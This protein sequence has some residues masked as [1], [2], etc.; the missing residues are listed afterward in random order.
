MIDLKRFL[1]EA[2]IN[3]TELAIAL[4]VTPQAITNLKQG[5]M[6]VPDDWNSITVDK[7]NLKLSD[8]LLENKSSVSEPEL[9]YINSDPKGK[10]IP[11]FEGQAFATISPSMADVVALRPD[12]F[13]HIP[14]FS[15]GEFALQ[16][17]GHSMRPYISHGDFVVVK[18]IMN[19]EAIIYDEPYMI[20]TKEDNLKT[21]KFVKEH[22]DKKRLWLVPYNIE[23]FNEQSIMKEDILEM[24]RVVGLFRTV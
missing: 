18:R 8:Y 16:I 22:K 12:T 6:G 10:K 24:Y 7:F 5:K 1:Y 23:Q 20:V 11:Y 2:K 15:Q 3:Q 17:T 13:I 9:P 21:V 4:G 19:R 14:M